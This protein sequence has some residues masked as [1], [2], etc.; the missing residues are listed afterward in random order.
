MSNSAYF[1]LPNVSLFGAGCL[2]EIGAQAV[3]LGVKKLLLVTDRFLAGTDGAARIRQYLR[4]SGV[5]LEVFDGVEPNPT[6]QSVNAAFDLYQKNGCDGVISLGGGSSH[7]CGKAVCILATTGA[8][9][10]RRSV[11]IP[12]RTH[13]RRKYH[14]RHRKRDHQL[15]YHY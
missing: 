10:W 14:C 11:Q 1:F 2:T 7:D 5:E 15:L 8:I 13:D 4:E 6:L 3:R 12:Q 9:C